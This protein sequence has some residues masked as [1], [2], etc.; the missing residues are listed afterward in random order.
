MATLADIRTASR[1]EIGEQGTGSDSTRF[2]GETGLDDKI[3]VAVRYIGTLIQ[4][5]REVVEISG[6]G[7]TNG[8]ISLSTLT[9]K[10]LITRKAYWGDKT[11]KG[12][13]FELDIVTEEV[14]ASVYPNWLETHSDFQGKPRFL[15]VKEIVGSDVTL[16]VIPPPNS[17]YTAS[18]QKLILSQNYYPET[19]D[20]SADVPQL[21]LVYHDLISIYVAHLCYGSGQMNNPQM[22]D[23]KLKEFNQKLGLTRPAVTKEAE[24]LQFRWTGNENIYE[25][26]GGVTP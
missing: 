19:L 5:P 12:N 8:A 11:V 10:N 18:G 15:I 13:L 7:L 21:P 22:S 9:R 24:S 1:K 4:F 17:T 23:F 14:V 2:T 20:D 16:Q 25:D 26:F 3:N 6:S